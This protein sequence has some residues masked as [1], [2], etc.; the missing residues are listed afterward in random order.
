MIQEIEK[1]IKLS[2]A[3]NKVINSNKPI[4]SMVA[5][6]GAGKTFIG[7]NW[8]RDKI[9]ALGD[10]LIVAPSYKMLQRSTL[11]TFL[12]MIKGTILE[13]EFKEVKMEYHC[14]Y[15]NSVIYFG[16]ADNPL[17]L[18]GPHTY[19][20]WID[21]AGLT[22]LSTFQVVLSRIGQKNGQLLI[23]TT[24]NLIKTKNWIY[25]EL[26]EKRKEDYI[27]YISSISI[28]NPSYSKEFFERMK[29]VLDDRT[30]AIRHL[31]KFIRNQGLVYFEIIDN[32][33]IDKN[34][35][36]EEYQGW[37]NWE[38]YIAIDPGVKY[39]ILFFA[40]NPETQR[41]LIY[42]EYITK[43]DR[44]IPAFMLAKV[45]LSRLKDFRKIYYDPARLTDATNLVYEIE[46]QGGFKPSLLMPVE[47]KVHEGISNVIRAVKENKLRVFNNLKFFKDEIESY[48]YP[49]DE[50][51][52][53]IDD[54]NPVKEDDDLM[55]AMRYGVGKISSSIIAGTYIS[56][57]SKID[58]LKNYIERR[59]EEYGR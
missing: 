30:F 54:L 59:K 56:Q 55:D 37:E 50:A 39:G 8:S 57:D 48:H 2:T 49:M 25:S 51:G 24:P 46:K 10:G 9:G 4:I 17:T 6:T 5:G 22:N 42:D 19:W 21:E 35:L 45:I 47:K 41:K 58:G 40:Y 12:E 3:Q 18:D 16:S 34:N 14:P 29:R 26:Y 36:P 11:P 44:P 38:H 27:D 15:N 20:A 33:F 1:K 31:A 43:G 13:G 28:D 23:T 7:A 52:R 53:I 32:I